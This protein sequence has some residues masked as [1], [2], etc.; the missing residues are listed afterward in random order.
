MQSGL[1][2]A[3]PIQTMSWLPHW[4]VHLMMRH[5]TVQN[6][7]RARA[8]VKQVAHNVQAVHSQ[9]LDDL[10]EADN[11]GVGAVIA[12]DALNDLAVILV[13]VVVLKVGVK[14]LVEDVTAVLR[15]TAAHMVAGMLAGH[16]PAQVD[17]PQQRHAIPGVQVSLAGFQLGQL[18][19][20]II[21]ERRQLG[22]L[23]G[24]DTGAK[25]RVDFF[26]DDA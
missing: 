15:Q 7:V 19:I 23:L 22:T 10:T 26:T 12:D 17:E 14:Q 5:Q 1:P 9:P 16:E 24:G 20:G 18:L 21:D 6:A 25:H 3:A 11:I 2:A 8:A 13:L 4:D